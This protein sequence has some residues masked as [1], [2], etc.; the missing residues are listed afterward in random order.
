MSLWSP[1]RIHARSLSISNRVACNLP[2]IDIKLL[3]LNHRKVCLLPDDKPGIQ[4]NIMTVVFRNAVKIARTISFH[5]RSFFLR[6]IPMIQIASPIST[7][8]NP[9]MSESIPHCPYSTGV[10]R[11]AIIPTAITIYEAVINLPNLCTN[12]F[13]STRLQK[14]LQ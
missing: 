7:R 2:L 1:V 8:S 12:L 13:I 5:Q 11:K 4:L 6:I 9:G 3:F 10:R 14:G